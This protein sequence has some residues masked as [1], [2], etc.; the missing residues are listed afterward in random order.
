MTLIGRT[1]EQDELGRLCESPRAEFAVVYGRRRVGKTFL[2][3][4]YFGGSFAFYASGVAGGKASVQLKGFEQGLKAAGDSGG[5]LADW[6]DA[7]ERL[8]T[9]LSMPNAKRDEASGKR[10]VFIDEMPWLDTPR[11]DFLAALEL[12]WNT[13]GSAQ[14]DLLLIACGSATS[15]I[16]DKLLKN[17]GGL[18][19]RVTSRIKLAPFTLSECE[20]YF[21]VNGLT[22]TRQHV[23]EAYM[24]FGGIPY[25][26]DLMHRRLGIVQNIDRLCFAE[27]APLK[28][29][30]DDLYHSLFKRAERHVAIV[31]A[32]SGKGYGMTRDEVSRATKIANGGTLT[33]TLSELEECGFIRS[34]RSFGKKKSGL[35]YQLIDPF[36]LFYLR[37]VEDATDPHFWSNRHQSSQVNSWRGYAFEL[38]CLL[39]SGQI[40]TALGIAV[41]ASDMCSWRSKGHDPAAQIDLVIDRSD[42]IIDLCEMKWAGREYSITKSYSAKLRDKMDVFAAETNTRKALRLVLVTPFGLKANAYANDVQAAIAAD[43]LFS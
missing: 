20:S 19:N 5:V 13:W 26:F 9:I 32:L 37:F 36:T 4:E 10:V 22:V 42:G 35:L 41:I 17:R 3:R 12:F 8:R 15:W 11:G 38:V 16:V 30:F 43:D 24:A 14:P 21:E 25:Y 40:K 33:K 34:Y 28:T 7:F 31:R 1:A 2:I 18:H 27:N 29:E 6:W 23:I 39:H